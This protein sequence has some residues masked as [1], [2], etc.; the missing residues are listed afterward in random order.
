MAA[1]LVLVLL[2]LI[3]GGCETSPTP[4]STPEATPPLD[5]EGIVDA[6]AVRMSNIT[7]ASFD[8][9]HDVGSS[10]LSEL[11]LYLDAVTGQIAMPDKYSLR[12]EA[13]TTDRNVF[14]GVEIIGV[15]GKAY[16]NLL[17]RWGETDPLTLPFDFSELGLRL[18]DIMRAVE[19]HTL[20]GEEMVAGVPAWRIG[21]LVD[22]GAFKGLL[23]NA[24]P[25]EPIKIDAWIGR[26]D[27]LL[28]QARVE[29]KLFSDDEPNA[30]RVLAITEVDVPVEIE[31]PPL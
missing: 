29:G 15:A 16:M 13:T 26:D 17:G 5:P 6:S 31:P 8:L 2:V 23:V 12:M 27:S 11:G 24:S 14:V 3:A 25:G 22:S 1:A 10:Y 21:G 20:I 7:Y 18:A 4:T 28:Y 19:E 30:V 9:D